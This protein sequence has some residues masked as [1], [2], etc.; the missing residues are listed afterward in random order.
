MVAKLK[1]LDGSIVKKL[2]A[3]NVGSLLI[4]LPDNFDDGMDEELKEKLRDI[5]IAVFGNFR[6]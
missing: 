6:V 1:E 4:V 5:E 3:E 2:L